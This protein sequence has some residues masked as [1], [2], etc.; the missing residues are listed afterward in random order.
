VGV[1]ITQGFRAGQFRSEYVLNSTS[2]CVSDKSEKL[3]M[4]KG[5]MNIRYLLNYQATKHVTIRIFT[6]CGF[7]TT[8][9]N[10]SGDEFYFMPMPNARI[11]G[12]LGIS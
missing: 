3:Q 11:A 12:S 10:W 7:E 8:N 4:H 1:V 2:T 6:L 9:I 5:N